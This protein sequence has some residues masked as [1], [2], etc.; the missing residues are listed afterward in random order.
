MAAQEQPHLFQ[1]LAQL[2]L[3]AVVEQHL[4][5]LQEQVEQ[6]GVVTQATLLVVALLEL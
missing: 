6:E 2:M 5:G 3:V 4:A 1:V